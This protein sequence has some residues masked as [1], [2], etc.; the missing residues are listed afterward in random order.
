MEPIILQDYDTPQLLP[1]NEYV[2]CLNIPGK[3]SIEPFEEYT[4]IGVL[5]DKNKMYYVHDIL[6][7]VVPFESRYTTL[8]R[9]KHRFPKH[10]TLNEYFQITP[11]ETRPVLYRYTKHKYFVGCTKSWGYFT[12]TNDIVYLKIVYD[13]TKEI[14][15]LIVYEKVPMVHYLY[16]YEDCG[17][18]GR[19]SYKLSFFKCTI[20]NQ[21]LDFDCF[22]DIVN[23]RLYGVEYDQV[24]AFR[25]N[26]PTHLQL[27]DTKFVSVEPDTFSR[28]F[29]TFLNAKQP[30][31]QS[32]LYFEAQHI[33][34]DPFDEDVTQYNIQLEDWFTKQFPWVCV[35]KR[36]AFLKLFWNCDSLEACYRQYITESKPLQVQ[37]IQ[38]LK[39]PK[40]WAKVMELEY[41]GFY[42]FVSPHLNEYKKLVLTEHYRRDSEKQKCNCQMLIL[43]YN[44]QEYIGPKCTL[45]KNNNHHQRKLSMYNKKHIPN[46]KQV[47]PFFQYNIIPH[48]ETETWPIFGKS[49]YGKFPHLKSELMIH[50][51]SRSGFIYFKPLDL[52]GANRTIT[53]IFMNLF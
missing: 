1:Q 41:S 4:L 25:L 2:C 15:D 31:L 43:K 21:N 49:Y 37:S 39:G 48:H 28:V 17:P 26:G 13:A 23:L 33:K 46:T 20:Q 5:S 19:E 16:W 22:Q 7:Y 40:E 10:W 45:V 8:L 35:T 11:N 6:D 18:E 52:D 47:Q 3:C 38:W 42:E 30:F 53:D 34:V 36:N 24:Y 27:I 51:T 14:N 29:Q 50:L 9:I 44:M 12:P 32:N